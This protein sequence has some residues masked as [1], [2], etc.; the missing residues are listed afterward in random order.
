[1]V[2]HF[3]RSEKLKLFS[4]QNWQREWYMKDFSISHFLSLD[5]FLFIIPSQAVVDSSESSFVSF[6]SQL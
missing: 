5:T 6:S 3:G 2:P 4:L 1:M